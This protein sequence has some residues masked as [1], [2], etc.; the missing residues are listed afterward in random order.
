M[1]ENSLLKEKLIIFIGVIGISF[2]GVLAKLPD[3]P[4]I[5][6][7]MCRMYFTVLLLAI[8]FLR[9]FRKERHSLTRRTVLYCLISGCFLAVHFASYFQAVR[10]ASVSSGSL[11]VNTSVFF[12]PMIT[13]PFLGEKVSLRALAGILITFLGS[14]IVA[15]ADSSGGSNV[16]LG[17]M[18]A[19]LGA[20]C[21]AV[22]TIMGKLCRRTISTSLYTTFVYFIAGTAA[23]LLTIAQGIPLTGYS[24]ANYACALGMAVLCTLLGHSIFNWGLKYLSAAYI[25]TV[26]LGEPVISAIFAYL[27]FREQ[28]GIF[29]VIGGAVILFGVAWTVRYSE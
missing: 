6:L 3:A 7:V 17:D 18:F 24:P 28:P 23:L 25:S 26:K 20:F 22:Y 13:V 1:N 16:L 10:L 21:M 27:I 12:V 29:K 11:L 14:V 5:Y 9:S 8:P 4:S 19:I 2:S 15:S